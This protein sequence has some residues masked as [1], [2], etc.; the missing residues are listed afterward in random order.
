M[1]TKKSTKNT[2]KSKETEFEESLEK[3]EE[4]LEYLKKQEKMES[5][6]EILQQNIRKDL[7][8]QLTSQGKFGKHFEDMVED[9]LYFIDLKERLK[10]DLDDRGIRYRAIG[11]NG[12]ATYKPNESYERLLKTNAE[13]LKILQELELK[14]PDDD[15]DDGDDLL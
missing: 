10:F 1:A 5:K 7:M 8:S 14:A 6:I 13:M 9:Y 2:K 12:F 11:G 15:G 3:T 4:N